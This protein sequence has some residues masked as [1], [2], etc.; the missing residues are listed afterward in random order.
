MQGGQRAA[1]T[2]SRPVGFLRHLWAFTARLA[3]IGNFLTSWLLRDSFPSPGPSRLWCL[4][5]QIFHSSI[6]R[7]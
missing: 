3:N 2:G 6:T 5:F 4:S 1:P 7:S